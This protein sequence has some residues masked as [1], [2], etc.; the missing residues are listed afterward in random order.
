MIYM[1]SVLSISNSLSLSPHLSLSVS[2]SQYQSL[3]KFISHTTKTCV[4]DV[5]NKR[6][7]KVQ[8]V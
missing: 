8:K 2:L 3:V 7:P 5:N 4:Y 1:A 6:K